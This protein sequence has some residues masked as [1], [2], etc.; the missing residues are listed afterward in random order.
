[1]AHT[2]ESSSTLKFSTEAERIDFCRGVEDGW[3]EA[4]TEYFDT[5]LEEPRTSETCNLNTGSRDLCVGDNSIIEERGEI[6]HSKEEET[7]RFEFSKDW[8]QFFA[9]REQL[10]V[11]ERIEEAKKEAQIAREQSE[12]IQLTL[13]AVHDAE[14]RQRTEKLYGKRGAEVLQEEARLNAI[15]QV[16]RSKRKATYWPILPLVKWDKS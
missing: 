4:W 9:R 16:A 11:E 2:T 7:A 5:L 1:M 10:R 15:F 12:N 13:G 8:A 6:E 14:Q 3:N